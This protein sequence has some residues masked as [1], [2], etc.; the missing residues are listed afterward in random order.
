MSSGDRAA[1]GALC[2]AKAESREMDSLRVGCARAS[3]RDQDHA[4]NITARLLLNWK[5][6]GNFADKIIALIYTHNNIY[7]K[8]IL[9]QIP[10]TLIIKNV[11]FIEVKFY[12]PAIIL[13]KHQFVCI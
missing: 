4:D 5:L 10:Y 6:F 7:I 3:T 11:S 1:I 13:D 8:L 12:L 2:G 9:K